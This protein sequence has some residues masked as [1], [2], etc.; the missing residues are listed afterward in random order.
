MKNTLYVVLGIDD[1][2]S[3][4][5]MA[6]AYQMH[7]KRLKH[8]GDNDAQ[9]ELK[10]IRQAYAVLSDPARRAKYDLSLKLEATQRNKVI[11]YSDETR[12]GGNGMLKLAVV[13]G[14]VLAAY[15]AYHYY[16]SPYL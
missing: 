3:L 1:Q 14:L 8:A 13:C 7:E 11:Y 5:E 10:L 16:Q 4:E 6:A 12:Q 9:N 2:T 15:L